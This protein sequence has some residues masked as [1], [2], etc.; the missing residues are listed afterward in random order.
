[1]QDRIFTGGPFVDQRYRTPRERCLIVA[2]N[3][4]EAGDLCFCDSM[5]TGPRADGDYDLNKSENSG[6]CLR[7]R[8][9]DKASLRVRQTACVCSTAKTVTDSFVPLDA[10]ITPNAAPWGPARKTAA[11]SSGVRL[12][13]PRLLRR[14]SVRRA[15]WAISP[16]C[17]N[18][19]R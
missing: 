8:S 2:V 16:L 14:A 4:T 11:S 7:S 1:M 10:N 13:A 19:F 3:C 17:G 12:R 18:C 9:K 6:K 5:G 15:R